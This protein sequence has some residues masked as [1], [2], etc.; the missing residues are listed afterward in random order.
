MKRAGQA[1]GGL[2]GADSC[3][4]TDAVEQPMQGCKLSCFA[5]V[6]LPQ[7]PAVGRACGEQGTTLGAGPGAGRMQVQGGAPC[8]RVSGQRHVGTHPIESLVQGL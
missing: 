3:T 2:I 8:L 1:E 5:S 6:T 4:H 7:D